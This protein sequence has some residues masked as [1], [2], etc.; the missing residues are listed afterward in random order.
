MSI[1]TNQDFALEVRTDRLATLW[2]VTLIASVVLGWIAFTVT[3]LQREYSPHGLLPPLIIIAA[4]LLTRE[5]LRRER[6]TPA[7][8]TYALG[9]VLAAAVLLYVGGQDLRQ[10]IPFAFSIIVFVVGLLLPPSSTFL[11]T[12]ISALVTVAVPLLTPDGSQFLRESG[13]Y[14]GVAIAFTFASALLSTLR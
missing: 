4:C 2:K 8:W 11:L 7:V 6:F 3:M 14:V 12:V 13:T 5:L 10:I 1:P 9:G